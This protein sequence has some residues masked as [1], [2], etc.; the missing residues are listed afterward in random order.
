MKQVKYLS[1]VLLLLTASCTKEKENS[2]RPREELVISGVAVDYSRVSEK[3]TLVIDPVVT[4]TDPGADL[5]Y[6][7]GIYPASA[8]GGYVGID[9]VSREKTLRYLVK[10]AANN[11]RLVLGVKNRNTGYARHVEASLTVTTTFTRG[12]YVAKDD[13]TYSD[14]D[15]FL[16]PASSTP[17]GV[18]EN[19]FSQVNGEKVLGRASKIHYFDTYRTLLPTGSIGFMKA[20]VLQTDKDVV[21]SDLNTLKK[22]KGFKDLFYELP[23]TAA[24]GMIAVA[25]QA[26]YMLNDGKLHAIYSTAYNTGVFGAAKMRDNL[27]TPYRLSKY[28]LSGSS[29]NAI[30]FDQ[31]SGSFVSGTPLGTSMVAITDAA[32]T[33]MPSGNTNMSMI[34]M[35]NRQHFGSYAGCALLQDKSDANLKVL[36]TITPVITAFSLDT[37]HV[38][39]AQKLFHA[40][41]YGLFDGDESMLYFAV[42]NEIWSRN[43]ANGNEVRQ[44]TLPA[45][46]AVSFIRHRKYPAD[47]LS[48]AASE[49]P[50]LY[51][52]VMVA[53]HTG[54]RYKI[55]MFK[56][57]SG[58][59]AAE[60]AF[61]LEGDGEAADAFYMSPFVVRYTYPDSY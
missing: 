15:L 9:T 39:P 6:W 58:N 38:R 5:E 32:Q 19:I 37:V 48:Y 60:P 23:A 27:N 44:F 42:G 1:W 53:S 47:K 35:A 24:P 33:D 41:H 50:F 3:D 54:G 22:G 43:L 17:D 13:G 49:N 8:S 31:V 61:T 21:L 52:L 7:W 20:L 14:M 11:W 18:L 45:G 12:W 16:T 28:F 30:F 2:G 59:I 40:T 56:K 4:S 57:T 55:R 26:F 25:S 51:N 34:Y 29:Y 36:A 10:Q 46:E